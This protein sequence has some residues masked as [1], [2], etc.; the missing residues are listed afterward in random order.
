MKTRDSRKTGSRLVFDQSG[1][2]KRL[3]MHSYCILPP[4]IR[5]SMVANVSL[6]LYDK[7]LWFT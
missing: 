2:L 4:E 1:G 6:E 5:A 7:E 3:T